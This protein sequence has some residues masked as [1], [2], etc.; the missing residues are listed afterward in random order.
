MSRP[1]PRTRNVN[2][3]LSEPAI[4]PRTAKDSTAQSRTFAHLQA[5][6]LLRPH[7]TYIPALSPEF[8]SSAIVDPASR[9]EAEAEAVHLQPKPVAGRRS[10]KLT[11]IPLVKSPAR[12][13]TTV[14]IL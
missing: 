8:R 9:A 6:S 1:H 10:T 12:W 2:S 14:K 5:P 3:P 13:R 11:P 7:P 4:Q